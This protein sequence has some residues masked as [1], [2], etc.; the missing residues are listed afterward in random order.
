[1]L[2]ELV[3]NSYYNKL[4]LV[5]FTP[6]FMVF[7]MCMVDLTR[8][9]LLFKS[10]FSNPYFYKYPHDSVS[11]LS[12]YQVLV[13][14]YLSV[15]FALFLMVLLYDNEFIYQH[16][17]EAFIHCMYL[18][19]GYFFVKYLVSEF[20]YNLSNKKTYFKQ[21]F[22]LETSYL[23]VWLLMVFLLLCYVF[24]HLNSFD[25][26]RNYLL[27]IALIAYFIRF[28]IIISNNKNLLSGKI[29]YI[30]LYL[31]T[32][33]IVPFIYLFKSYTE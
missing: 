9:K 30:I 17:F 11:T 16:F 12:L 19:T 31:C 28:I 24:L 10:L 7:L 25:I 4:S 14:L 5:L 29:L 3:D 8:T 20:L 1:M 26:S 6:L 18:S 33:E 32:L 15:V 23:V 21:T 27:I 13:F 22:M 2:L